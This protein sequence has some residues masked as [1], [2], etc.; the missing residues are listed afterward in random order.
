MDVCGALCSSEEGIRFTETRVTDTCELY[1]W[2]QIWVPHK[3][4]KHSFFFQLLFSYIISCL[5][6]LLSLF[7]QVFPLPSSHP[8]FPR[9]VSLQKKRPSRDVRQNY[10]NKINNWEQTLT[11]R[12]D[13]ANQQEGRGPEAQAKKSEIS[14]SRTRTSSYATIRHMQRTQLSQTHLEVL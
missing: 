1:P 5:Q 14:P 9:S 8:Q 7:L 2:N 12:L 4:N 3:S 13:K 6:F 10:P 11:A